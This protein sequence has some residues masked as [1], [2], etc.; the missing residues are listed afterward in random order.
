MDYY[1]GTLR[2]EVPER[3]RGAI[4]V[5]TE[6]DVCLFADDVKQQAKDGE[7]LK[8]LLLASG[9]W[10]TDYKWSGHQRNAMC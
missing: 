10:A 7:T 5:E 6:E 9:K 2:A 1:P 4:K 3:G 8:R